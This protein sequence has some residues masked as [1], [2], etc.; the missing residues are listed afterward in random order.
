M[1]LQVTQKK[2]QKTSTENSKFSH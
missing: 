2:H 1:L